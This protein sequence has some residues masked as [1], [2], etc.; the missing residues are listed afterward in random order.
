MA[1]I[2]V[3]NH[4]FLLEEKTEKTEETKTKEVKKIIE[5]SIKENVKIIVLTSLDYNSY[6]KIIEFK[7]KYENIT[8]KDQKIK[9]Y[10]TLGMYPY[11]TLKKDSEEGFIKNIDL[12]YKRLLK[13]LLEEKDNYT[14][15]GEIGLDFKNYNENSE[16]AKEDI[17]IFE[18]QLKIAEKIKKTVIIHSRKAEKKVY[19]I[20]QKYDIK[21]VLHSYTGKIKLAKKIVEEKNVYFSIPSIILHSQQFQKLV[22][23]LPI[24]RILTETDMPYM[25]LKTQKYSIPKNVKLTIKKIAEI[26]KLEEKEVEN[27]IYKNFMDIL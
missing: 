7:K 18:E 12:D 27:I 1:Y 4:M 21:K 17:K 11:N 2:D 15:M 22:E 23:V 9:F 14:F 24:N 13:K 16:E 8:Y 25:P 10:T 3:H 19:E 26:K 6:K 20:I 5:E